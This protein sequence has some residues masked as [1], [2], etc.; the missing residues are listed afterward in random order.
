MISG[1]TSG[2]IVRAESSGPDFY[3]AF[4]AT[5]RKL[6]QRLLRVNS[7]CGCTVA[8]NR[9]CPKRQSTRRKHRS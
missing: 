9:K 7:G 2:S 4:D 5:T 8:R 6:R 3:V 1:W